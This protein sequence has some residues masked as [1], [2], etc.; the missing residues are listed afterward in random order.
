LIVKDVSQ[1]AKPTKAAKENSMTPLS[2]TPASPI[3]ERRNWKFGRGQVG[4]R[5]WHGGDAGRTAFF[6]AL[7]STFPVGEKFFMTAVRHYRDAAPA[8]LRDQIDDFIFQESTH[9]REH[10]FFNLQARNAG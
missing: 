8:Q 2:Q 4:R 6:N 9:S 10:V 7:S 3:I 5:W 1:N